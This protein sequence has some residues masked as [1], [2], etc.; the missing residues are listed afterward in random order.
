MIRGTHY[1]DIHKHYN[2]AIGTYHRQARRDNHTTTQ[3]VND[4][5][6]LAIGMSVSQMCTKEQLTRVYYNMRCKCI[7]QNK[8]SITLLINVKI[9]FSSCHVLVDLEITAE[10]SLIPQ[11][12]SLH[13]AHSFRKV[14]QKSFFQIDAWIQST[15]RNGLV[16]VHNNQPI[17]LKQTLKQRKNGV[18]TSS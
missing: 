10:R 18:L 17:K 4:D 11:S 3:P 1:L 8:L 13:I 7:K 14:T 5:H 2:L 12:L 15:T 9:F 6:A 16:S